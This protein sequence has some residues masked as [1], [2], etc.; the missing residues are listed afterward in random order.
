[1]IVWEGG[2]RGAGD[3]SMALAEG[4]RARRWPVDEVKTV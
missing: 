3:H 2:S 4:A 1:L